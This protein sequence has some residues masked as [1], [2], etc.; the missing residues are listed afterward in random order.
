[1]GRFN[2]SLLEHRT[3]EAIA[4][5]EYDGGCWV[6]RTAFHRFATRSGTNDTIDDSSSTTALFVQ[7]EL[8][9]LASVGSSPLSL[10]KR[11]VPGYGKINETSA[12][13]V[14]SDE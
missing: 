14:F 8:N 2:R 13:S 4:G 1:V 5:L 7:L 6:F 3:T 11:S 9:G 12:T 10:L